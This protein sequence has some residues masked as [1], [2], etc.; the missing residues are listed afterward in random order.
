MKNAFHIKAMDYRSPE[1]L[2]NLTDEANVLGANKIA[3]AAMLTVLG[4]PE[5]ESGDETE[6][7][8]AGRTT[9]CCR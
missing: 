4:N 9:T 6:T 8:M 5:E 7:E 1:V 2:H 3:P